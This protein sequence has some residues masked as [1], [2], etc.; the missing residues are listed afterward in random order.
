M[1]QHLKLARPSV[2]KR[3]Y[4]NPEKCG[5]R[6]KDYGKS[7]NIKDYSKEEISDMLKGVYSEKGYLLTDGDYFINVND[8]IQAGC[9][10]KT[11]TSPRRLNLALP[12]SVDDVRTFYVKD[13]YLIT[14]NDSSGPNKHFINSYLVKAKA[15]RIGHWRYRYFFGIANTDKSMQTLNQNNI[16]QSLFNPIKKYI[17]ELFFGDSYKIKDFIVDSELQIR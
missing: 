13:Y 9:T 10:L 2:I 11:V 5:L 1:K 3:V 14:R 17:N 7:E 4:S 12:I 16:P 6:Y 15:V 8:V